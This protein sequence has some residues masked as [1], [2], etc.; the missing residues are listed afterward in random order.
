MFLLMKKLLSIIVLGLLLSGNAYAKVIIFSKCYNVQEGNFKFRDD[1]FEQNKYII[2]TNKGT[3]NNLRVLTD[4][5][6][7]NMV[8]KNPDSDI[9]KYNNY[10]DKITT[11]NEFIVLHKKVV[12]GNTFEDI[13]DLKKKKIQ[14]KIDYNN[15]GGAADIYLYQCQ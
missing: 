7:I 2:D 12:Y 10:Q 5:Y 8:K 14:K 15:P 9:S 13:Y 11:H 4:K 6:L 1:L 3:I